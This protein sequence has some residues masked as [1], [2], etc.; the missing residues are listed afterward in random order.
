M[1]TALDL[2]MID[3]EIVELRN[4]RHPF[5]VRGV[6]EASIVPPPAAIANASYHATGVRMARLPM[7]PQAVV[8]MLG[9]MSPS[10]R[11]SGSG[12]TEVAKRLR[13]PGDEW[14][15]EGIPR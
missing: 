6:G 15:R 8:E 13:Q 5:G 14:S 9:I 2:T 7:T 1:P 3:T 11:V 10:A 12:T 4:P